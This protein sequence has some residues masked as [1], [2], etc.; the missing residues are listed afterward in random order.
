MLHRHCGIN[1]GLRL[2]AECRL[3]VS[4]YT[5]S[6]L[7]Q[8]GTFRFTLSCIVKEI[9]RRQSCNFFEYDLK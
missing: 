8:A 4:S 6:V 2:G 9:F 3:S 7:A 5:Y 1:N